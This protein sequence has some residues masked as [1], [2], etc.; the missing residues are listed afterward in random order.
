MPKI[1]RA[2]LAFYKAKTIPWWN[3]ASSW[4]DFALIRGLSWHLWLRLWQKFWIDC[5]PRTPPGRVC[6]L[7]CWWGRRDSRKARMLT[8]L[9]PRTD[10]I[11][12]QLD[13]ICRQ[14]YSDLPMIWTRGGRKNTKSKK[15]IKSRQSLLV[16]WFFVMIPIGF[17][18]NRLPFVYY[19]LWPLFFPHR[20][21]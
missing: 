8:S 7:T 16:S 11:C 13:G 3:D 14:I 2:I 17:S 20:P 1:Y 19:F 10:W 6:L 9:K 15:V 12:G 4:P 21:W 5:P 18:E